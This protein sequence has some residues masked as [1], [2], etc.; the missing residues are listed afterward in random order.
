M[1]FV[2]DYANA[3]V[4]NKNLFGYNIRNL[5]NTVSIFIM[6]MVNPDGVNLVT[7]S[8]PTNSVAFNRALNIA[9]SFPSISF[10]SRLES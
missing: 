2:E 10:P 6:P 8:L 9:N 7:N 5:F 3:Y 4:N 1:K